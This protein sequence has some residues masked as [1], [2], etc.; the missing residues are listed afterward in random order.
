MFSF[1]HALIYSFLFGRTV[2]RL[3][4][5]PTICWHH[6][7]Q[8]IACVGDVVFIFYSEC[9][10]HKAVKCSALF[11]FGSLCILENDT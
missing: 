1:I 4:T 8:C 3:L 7:T 6:T 2:W 9:L 10:F 5:P 11:A